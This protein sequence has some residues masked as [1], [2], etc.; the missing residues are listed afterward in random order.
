MVILV[1]LVL[2][3]V[4]EHLHAVVHCLNVLVEVVSRSSCSGCIGSGGG[5]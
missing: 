2:L 4:V 3:P 5:I 1:D